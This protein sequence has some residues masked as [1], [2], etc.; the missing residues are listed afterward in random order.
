MPN[1]LVDSEHKLMLRLMLVM[2]CSPAYI[3]NPYLT[4]KIVEVMFVL[5]PAIQPK[6][7]Q[8]NTEILMS[9]I[10]ANNLVPSLMRFY[11]GR[12]YIFIFG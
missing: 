1:S 5:Q 8:L 7:E 6:T 9:E 2:L 3:K 11:T 12:V 10:G 4:A